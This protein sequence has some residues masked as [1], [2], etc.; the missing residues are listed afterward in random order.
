MKIQDQIQKYTEEIAPE[1]DALKEELYN[2]PELSLEEFNSSKAHHRLLKKHG[3]QVEQPFIGMKTA[4]RAVYDS[5]KEGPTI[6][7]MSEYDALPDIG[8][9]CGHNILGAT[10]TGAGIVLSKLLKEIGGKVI[11]LGTPA[12]ETSGGKVAMA[13]QGVFKE[14]DAALM[15]HPFTKYQLSGT[16]LSM[17]TR[18]YE[19]FGQTAHA[20]GSPELGKNALDSQIVLFSSLNAYRQQMKEDGRIHGVIVDGGKAANVIPDY[21]DSRFYVRAADKKYM[22]ELADQLDKMANASAMATNCEVKISEYELPY[23][24]LVSN[25]HL[26]DILREALKT[27]TEETVFEPEISKGS[28][29]AGNVSHVCPTVHGYFPITKDQSVAAHTRAFAQASM[30][31]YAHD[32]MV[33]TVS[34]LAL[35]GYRLI[36]EKNLLEKVKEEYQKDL[37]A[38]KIL[39]PKNVN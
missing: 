2:H 7:Y 8:H 3:F 27:Y 39:P 35:C 23:D 33:V 25:H 20:A 13:E 10:S 30:S 15:M 4:F 31:D 32:S 26:N 5:K 6:C 37:A 12:E 22:L 9:G 14:I 21:T 24:N 34:A 18:R 16:S 11:V 1:L 28:L 29:D 38:G 19:F 17:V 36:T